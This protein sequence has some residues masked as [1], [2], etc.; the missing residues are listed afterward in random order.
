MKFYVGLFWAAAVLTAQ[1]QSVRLAPAEPASRAAPSKELLRYVISWNNGLSLGEAALS[2]AQSGEGNLE[3]TFQ[4]EA[5][6]PKFPVTE[7]MRG[8]ANGEFCTVESEKKA[9]RGTR[10]TDEKTTFDQQKLSATRETIKGGKSTFPIAACAKD[11]VSFLYF[12]RRELAQGRLP[13]AA[14]VYYGAPYQISMQAG[15]NS[16]IKVGDASFDTEK[17]NISIKGPTADLKVEAF[18][19]KNAARV[20]LQIRVPIGNNTLVMEQQR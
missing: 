18:F 10:K 14:T 9:V 19:E 2:S 16:K 20:P 5:A 13:K 8:L 7:W 4:A 3:F 17:V 1:T 11:A 12:L 15:G 6:V